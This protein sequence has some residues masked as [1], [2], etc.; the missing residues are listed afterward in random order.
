MYAFSVKDIFGDNGITVLLICKIKE[1]LKEVFIDTFLL[2]CR[3]FGR[4]IEKRVLHF[5]IQKYQK[6]FKKII[7][8]LNITEKIINLRIFIRIT[9]L[10]QSKLKKTKYIFNMI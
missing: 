2:S 5:I 9:I 4:K 6:K 1:H 10:G 7:S 8:S 3:V